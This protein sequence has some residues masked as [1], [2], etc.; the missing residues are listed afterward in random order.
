LFRLLGRPLVVALGLVLLAVMPACTRSGAPD[1]RMNVLV[2]LTD[3]QSIETLPHTPPIMPFLQ[4]QMQDRGGEWVRFPNAFINTPLCCPSRASLLTGEYSSHTGVVNN[5]TGAKLDERSTLATWLSAS[6]YR[7]ALFGKYLNDY[8]FDR[9]AYVPPGWDHWFAKEQGPQSTTYSGYT[10]VDDGSPIRYG[11]SPRDYLTSVLTRQATSWISDAPSDRPFF[12]WFAPTA[13]HFPWTPAPQDRGAFADVTIE[14][15]PSVTENVSDKPAWV[16]SLPPVSRAQQAELLRDRRLEYETL[17]SVDRSV[18]TLL[19]ALRRRGA[20]EHTVVF[21][22]TDNGFS[23]GE[24]RWITKPCEYEPCIDTPFLVRYPGASQRDDPSLV[25]NVDVAPTI[26]DIANVS[27]PDVDGESLL[28]QLTGGLP[29]SRK[30]VLVEWAGGY[31]IPPFWEVR[32]KELAYVELQTGERELYDLA[33]V[34]GKP[35]PNELQNR[36]GDPAYRHVQAKL[37]NLLARLKAG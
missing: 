4:S 34:V 8:P 26:A 24:H 6:G 20:L 21:F 12:A 7:T 9:G 36:A 2:I 25:S 29:S 17:L 28:P 22:L 30:G 37:A 19:N 16:R 15:P 18:E 27:T 1:H 5:E 10:I 13:P 35:D 32:T 31:A 33:G 3:D 14:Q 23:F 11:T